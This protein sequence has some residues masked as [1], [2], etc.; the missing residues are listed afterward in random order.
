MDRRSRR[1]ASPRP[2]LVGWLACA[3]AGAGA[4]ARAQTSSRA[5]GSRPDAGT[6]KP[7]A[8]SA[9]PGGGQDKDKAGAKA[10]GKKEAAPAAK[11][12]APR[13]EPSPEFQESI[14]KTIEKR[15]ERRARRA[16]ALGT[17]DGQPPGAIVPWPMPP[18]LIIRQTPQVHDEID[19]L[20]GQLRRG[21]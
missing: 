9:K 6:S 8:S 21:G 3:L 12:K 2:F 17:G 18:A 20:L 1:I 4:P 7:P 19:S 5:D 15:R 11:D 16:Q 13:G 10:E 14:R